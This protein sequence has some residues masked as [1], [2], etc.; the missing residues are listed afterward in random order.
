[1][2]P[3]TTI[4]LSMTCDHRPFPLPQDHRNDVM[5]WEEPF[6]WRHNLMS[7]LWFLKRTSNLAWP[8]I[9]DPLMTSYWEEPFL[10][11][12][13][14]CCCYGSINEHQLGMNCDHRP[15]LW[16]RDPSNDVIIWRKKKT[17][18]PTTSKLQVLSAVTST[19]TWQRNK[20]ET[21]LSWEINFP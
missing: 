7:L 19:V 2:I 21:A 1:M 14:L 10:C 6:L 8:A 20:T 16:T 18:L 15:F 5:T 17:Q 3:E 13:I 12:I 11:D 4:K 9:V